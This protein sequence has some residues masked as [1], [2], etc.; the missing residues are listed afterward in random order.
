MNKYNEPKEHK[1]MRESI[2][3][4]IEAFFKNGGEIEQVGIIKRDDA[5]RF[6]NLSKDGM[7]ACASCHKYFD[8]EGN[9]NRRFCSRECARKGNQA[10]QIR[11]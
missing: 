5:D 7:K 2:Q 4:Q 10:L 8:I 9:Q 1:Q 11:S 3:D 6:N